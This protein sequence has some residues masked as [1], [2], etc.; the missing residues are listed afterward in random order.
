[1]ALAKPLRTA[2]KSGRS[3]RDADSGGWSMSSFLRRFAA[4]VVF[5]AIGLGGALAQQKLDQTSFGTNW[6]AQAEHGGFYQ[7]VAD[8]TYKKYNLEVKIVPGGPQSNNRMMLPVGR[9]DFYMG[10]NMIQ[11]FS[12]VQENIPTLVVAAIFQKDPQVILAHPGQG[13]DTFADLK[14]SNDILISKEGLASFYQWMKT[15]FGFK[16]EQTK[17]YTYNPAPFITNK[18]AVQQGYV[19]S[20]PYAIEQQAGF[21]PVV[22]LLADNGFSTYATTVETRRD[23]VEKN[24]DLVRRF[25]E[26]S[27]IGWYNYLY[28]DNKAAN[29]LIRKDN[30][31]MTDDKIAFAIGKM[32]E[33]GIVDSGDT[34]TLGI[35]AMTDERVKDFF[36]KMVRAGLFPADLDYRKS[37]SLQFVNKSVGNELR[38]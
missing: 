28:G 25:V 11:A 36:D 21:K 30:P 2:H 1:M 29:E 3:Q 18:K 14:K 22:H 33:Y 13:F 20:E 16:E 5:F 32:K 35:G 15:E 27:I 10:G 8:G 4:G 23:L 19:T 9:L 34:A 24:P 6:V 7:A 17:P 26:A 38:K 12:A 37:Y 31:E